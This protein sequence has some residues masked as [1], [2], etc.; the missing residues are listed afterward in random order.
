MIQHQPLVQE[1]PRPLIIRRM[2]LYCPAFCIFWKHLLH[3]EVVLGY[4]YFWFNLLQLYLFWDCMKHTH[5]VRGG[6]WPVFA[7]FPGSPA[8]NGV[9]VIWRER[10]LHSSSSCWRLPNILRKRMFSQYW[11]IW[12]KLACP[13]INQISDQMISFS[14]FWLQRL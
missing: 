12:V 7:V 10:H 11:H 3:L 5:A 13:V 1:I 9:R 8:G 6:V 2:I 4:M 14:F